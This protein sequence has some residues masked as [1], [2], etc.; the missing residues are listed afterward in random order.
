MLSGWMSFLSRG[1]FLSVFVGVLAIVAPCLAQASPDL[2]L[3]ATS[4][5][6][7][8]CLVVF[9]PEQ[10]DVDEDGF[11]D[12]CDLTLSSTEDPD[13]VDNGSLAVNP[14]NLNLKSQG[15][16][17]TTFLELPAGVAPVDIDLSSLRLEGVLPFMSP[18][19]PKLGDGDG[20]GTPDLMVKFS[21]VDL[22][23]LL[24]ETGRTT[25]DVVLTMTGEVLELP[26][27]VR[28]SV[29]VK[30]QCP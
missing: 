10:A 11:G 2:D 13:A 5:A 14:K 8:N 17:V 28:G 12:A 15:R 25:G 24:C 29:H 1:V 6:T 27:E 7:D 19:T 21:R 9:N 3:D 30:G 18:P 4:D 20:D 26:F 23:N 22:I 16:V